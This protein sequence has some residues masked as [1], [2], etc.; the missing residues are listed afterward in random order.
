MVNENINKM[1]RETTILENIFA[2]ETLDKGLIY[3]IYRELTQIHT[4]KTNN[5]IKKW[6]KNMNRHFFKQDIQRTQ[7]HM[8]RFSASLAV[9]EMQNENDSWTWTTV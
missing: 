5:P 1:K 4:R 2:N 8:K 9:R 3:Q 6:A 7:R